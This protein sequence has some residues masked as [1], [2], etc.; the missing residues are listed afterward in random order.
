M[1][2]TNCN[3]RRYGRVIIGTRTKRRREKSITA[4]SAM[5][6]TMQA[7]QSVE[8]AAQLRRDELRP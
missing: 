7:M 2:G 3:R 5:P 4:M 1:D 8:S 6:S